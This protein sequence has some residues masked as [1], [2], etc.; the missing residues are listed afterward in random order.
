MRG[1][2][3]CRRKPIEA[4][5]RSINSELSRHPK[6]NRYIYIRLSSSGMGGGGELYIAILIHHP[7]CCTFRQDRKTG[8]DVCKNNTRNLS[9][10]FLVSWRVSSAAKSHKSVQNCIDLTS[11]GSNV[12]A[13]VTNYNIVLFVHTHIGQHLIAEC[14]GKH[15][16][17]Q[18][19]DKQK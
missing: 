2:R 13:F 16:K 1:E 8:R 4:C 6:K 3:I 9:A 15:S 10:N 14:G 5:C 11:N 12:I 19:T 18:Q 17:Q 7:I